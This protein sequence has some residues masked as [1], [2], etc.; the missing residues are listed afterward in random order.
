MIGTDFMPF[1]GKVQRREDVAAPQQHQQDSAYRARDPLG[2]GF[3]V[4][5]QSEAGAHAVRSQA[6][7]AGAA[8]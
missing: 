7:R 8:N 6:Q 2:D 3:P 4:H 1:D 5:G